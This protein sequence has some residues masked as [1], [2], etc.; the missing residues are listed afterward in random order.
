M[1]LDEFCDLVLLKPYALAYAVE[2]EPSPSP[3]K[4]GIGGDPQNLCQI[5]GGKKISEFGFHD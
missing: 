3:I 1:G 4:D 5:L 2:R